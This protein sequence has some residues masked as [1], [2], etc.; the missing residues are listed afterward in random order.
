MEK[1]YVSGSISKDFPLYHSSLIPIYNPI[2]KFSPKTKN[3]SKIRITYSNEHPDIFRIKGMKEGGYINPFLNNIVKVDREEYIKK[4]DNCK[5]KIKLIDTI[6]CSRKISQD[7]KILSLIKNDEHIRKRQLCIP[8]IYSPRNISFSLDN[9]KIFNKA[10]NSLNQGLGKTAKDF[11]K[12][13]IDFN[14]IEKI[15]NNYLISKNDIKKIKNISCAFD[16]NKS[17]YAANSN[18][19]KISDAQTKDPNKEFNYPRK[20]IYQL[21]PISNKNQT[22]YPPPF[23]FP[24]WGAFSENYYILSNTK[25][26]FNKKG[27]LFSELVNKN[28]DKI[29]VMREDAR[30]RLKLDK[31]NEKMENEKLLQDTGYN[32][33]LNNYDLTQLN[34][35]NYKFNSLTPSNSIKNI[36]IGKKI[37]EMYSYSDKDKNKTS[38]NNTNKNF[39]KNFNSFNELQ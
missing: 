13:N 26:G 19:Y 21:N 39:L 18:D 35:N 22:L 11:T 9:K 15:G 34:Q 3:F 4:I 8:D 5:K 33:N 32:L 10:M 29:K 31:E 30:R 23:K 17:S 38:R 20:P 37:K 14:Q 25:K 36:L 28:I 2:G 6:K 1:T 12:K 16:I 27:G 7:P 24:R